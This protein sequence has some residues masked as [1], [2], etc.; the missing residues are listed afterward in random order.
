MNIKDNRSSFSKTS[1]SNLKKNKIMEH[2]IRSFYYDNI[3]D[4]L[5]YTAEMLCSLY[6]NDLWKMYIHF[7]CKYIHIHNIKLV[8]YLNKKFEEFKSIF[9]NIQND[10]E[11]RNDPKMRHLFFTLT[12]LFCK[13]KKENVLTSIPIDFDIH[14]INENL[15][16]DNIEY[17]KFYFK[18]DPK[19]FYIPFNEFIYHLKETKNIKQ[20]FYWIDWIIEYDYFLIKRKKQVFIEKRNFLKLNNDNKNKNIIWFIWDIL[21]QYSTTYHGMINKTMW[22]LFNLFKIKYN[23][24]NN[25]QYKCILYVCVCLLIEN[26]IET[27]IKL[28]ENIEVFKDIE[29]KIKEIFSEIKKK[30][31]WKEEDKSE[32]QKLYDSVYKI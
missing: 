5:Y 24:H 7:Y 11:I 9:K 32:K 26:K 21:L 22:C 1:F 25:K 20:L 13:T 31:V 28:I 10:F 27:D 4:A 17:A 29:Q 18:D 19:E 6:I 12:I 3:K 15:C 30:E 14:K 2:C 23:Y 16:A 8:I